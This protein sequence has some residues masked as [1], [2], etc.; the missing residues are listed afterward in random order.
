MPSQSNISTTSPDAPSTPPST[1]EMDL[2]DPV[3]PKAPT[4]VPTPQLNLPQNP[5]QST[6]S[7]M[8]PP[9]IIRPRPNNSTSSLLAPSVSTLP[10]QSRPRQKV[11]LAPGHSPLDWARLKS[12]GTDLRVP[13]SLRLGLMGRTR[14]HR[15]YYVFHLQN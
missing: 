3:T 4:A 11:I 1:F 9:S 10:P 12:S 5:P 8:P 14:R 7:L 15:I 2:E 13:L 6:N